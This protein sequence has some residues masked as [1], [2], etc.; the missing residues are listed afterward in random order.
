[1]VL[2]LWLAPNY[3]RL[4]YYKS[5]FIVG[6]ITQVPSLWTTHLQL[7]KITSKEL[8]GHYY[9]TSCIQRM[10]TIS[11]PHIQLHH[12]QQVWK[13]SMPVFRHSKIKS[14][15]CTKTIYT[16]TDKR[17]TLSKRNLSIFHKD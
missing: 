13:K 16:S 7:L 8:K 3:Y 5:V 17:Y 14:S 15:H 4:C 9:K 6:L 1:M 10:Y 2:N 11:L 12:P